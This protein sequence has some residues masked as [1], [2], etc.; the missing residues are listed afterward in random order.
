MKIAFIADQHFGSKND[1]AVMLDYME[2]FYEQVF[3]PT[4]DQRGIKTVVSLGDFMDRRKYVNYNTLDRVYKMF[5]N[6][7][8]ERGIHFYHILGNHDCYFKNTNRVNSFDLLFKER[9]DL[10]TLIDKPMDYDIA[11][12]TFACVPWITTDNEDDCKKFMADTDTNICL[13]HFELQGYELMRGVRMERGM[14]PKLLSKFDAVYSGHFH[15]RQKS[16]SISY[17]GTPYQLNMSDLHEKKG[18][19]IFDTKTDDTEYI[20]NPLRLFYRFDYDED[21][22]EEEL[23]DFANENV[24]E[25]AYIRVHTLNKKKESKFD[26]FMEKLYTY[27][28]HNVVVLD[29]S[30]ALDLALND[31]EIPEEIKTQ[32]IMSILVTEIQKG[33]IEKKKPEHHKKTDLLNILSEIHDESLEI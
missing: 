30:S 24:L 5:V 23:Q 14:S 12:K 11:D 33:F 9:S 7:M 18:F 26:D 3:F 17:I 4:L 10:F 13:G 15:C 2:R 19:V 29:R 25:G 27:N 28:P 22:W 32:D 20:Q 6:P 16:G 21:E 1:S 31:N 8:I